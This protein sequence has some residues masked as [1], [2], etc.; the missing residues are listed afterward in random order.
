M[1]PELLRR[2]LH[3]SGGRPW[4]ERILGF[5]ARALAVA[6]DTIDDAGN[7]NKGDNAHAGAA[8]AKKGI[9]LENF[10]NQP[11]PGA[12]GFPGGIQIGI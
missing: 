8:E 12:A 3:C 5:A 2:A 1:L 9:G 10:P 4:F 6:Q 7:C 11:S